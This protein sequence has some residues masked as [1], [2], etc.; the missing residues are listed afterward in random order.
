MP[1]LT[2]HGLTVFSPDKTYRYAVALPR[3]GSGRSSELGVY[4]LYPRSP[5]ET[6]LREAVKLIL[7]SIS[8][9]VTP[10]NSAASEAVNP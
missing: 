1:S 5:R 8:L 9:L 4:L 6:L 3:N 7:K 2:E 10:N